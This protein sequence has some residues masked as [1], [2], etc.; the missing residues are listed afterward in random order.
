MGR[1]EQSAQHIRE[2]LNKRTLRKH[3]NAIVFYVKRHLR[4]K[5]YW[6]KILGKMDKFMKQRAITMWAENAHLAHTEQL[7]SR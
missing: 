3:F 6:N 4:A 2:T 5:R 7:L 1:N